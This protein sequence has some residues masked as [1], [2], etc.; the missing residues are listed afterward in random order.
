MVGCE[1]ANQFCFFSNVYLLFMSTQFFMSCQDGVNLCTFP[2]GT[3]SRSGRL[4]PFK[5][6]A[7]KMAH[8]AGAPVIPISICGAANI[9]PSYWMF[10][11]RPAGGGACTVIVHEPVES[12]GRSEE[13]LATAVRDSIIAGLP[14]EQRPLL[15]E[16]IEVAAAA[17]MVTEQPSESTT[18]KVELPNE[19]V[20]Q[21]MIISAVS[22]NHFPQPSA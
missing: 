12:K 16:G 15:A 7:F 22:E 6:G 17:V 21:P 20:V 3:R 2:E 8:K 5:N 11:Y 18:I 1:Y 9:M 4:M 10:P 14:E 13:E 19:T